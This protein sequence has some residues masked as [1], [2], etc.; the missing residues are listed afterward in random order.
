MELFEGLGA[1]TRPLFMEMLISGGLSC[2]SRRPV[3]CIVA[4]GGL[5]FALDVAEEVGIPLI[6]FETLSLVG[7][8]A[9]FCLPKLIDA[10]EFPFQGNDLDVPIRSV[11]GMEAFLRRRD[12]PSFY[13]AGDLNIPIIQLVLREGQQVPRSRGLILNTFE[14][15]DGHILSHMRAF[16]PNLYPIGPLHLHLK[17]RIESE[18]KSESPPANSS[19]SLWEEDRSCV[20]W[21]DSHPPRSVIFVSIGSLAMMTRDQVMEFWHGLVN[22]GKRFLWV[23]RPNS[24]IDG[25][26]WEEEEEEVGQLPAEIVA[27]TKERG[28]IVS[29]APQEEVLRHRAVGGFLTHSG[30]NSTL[31]SLVERVPMLCWPYFVDQQVNSRFVSEVWR[32][33]MDMKDSCDRAVVEKMIKELMDVRRDEFLQSADRMAEMAAKSVRDGGSSFSNLN[34]LIEDIRLMV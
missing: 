3:T 19:T 9:Y 26:D 10:G 25:G 18:S 12:L 5:T 13:R 30:W 16:C 8:W 23:R 17:L 34:R 1:V 33:G 11:P 20:T 15:L 29:W 6:Y 4:D 28:K 24:V 31:E 14:E 27:A 2:G 21:L 32:V 22:S 7:L